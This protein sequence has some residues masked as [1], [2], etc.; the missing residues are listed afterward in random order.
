MALNVVELKAHWNWQRDPALKMPLA[1]RE[2]SAPK[3]QT[4]RS[5]W[6]PLNHPLINNH[7]FEE[8]RTLLGKWFDKWTESQRKQVLQD[9]FSRC[10]AGQ[11]KYLRRSLCSQVPDEALDF[12]SVLPRV[13]SLYIFS[14]L[15]PRSL[16]RCA[17]K[18]VFRILSKKLG[19]IGEHAFHCVISPFLYQLGQARSSRANPNATTQ[20]N[21]KKKALSGSSYR[22]RK[23]KSLMF[24]SLERVADGKK[25]PQW[26][27]QSSSALS[28]N[29]DPEKRLGS[30]QWNAG[31]RPGPQCPCW[32]LSHGG[33]QL[34]KII[35]ICCHL[36]D[37]ITTAFCLKHLRIPAQLFGTGQRGVSFSL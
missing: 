10:T 32:K 2:T 21:T 4:K 26:A 8:R 1:F 37:H 12:T 29:K 9:L 15:D 18:L 14:Y 20:E 6:T 22:L 3:M 11:L 23:A 31:I 28:A 33:F 30:S 35:D 34:Q 27:K 24:L 5:A 7:V 17:Q 36:A 13:I 16:C 25:R 19:E